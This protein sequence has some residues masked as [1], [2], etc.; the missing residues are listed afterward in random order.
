MSITSKPFVILLGLIT[1]AL[2]VLA[3]VLWRR[4]SGRG[5]APVLGRVALLVVGQLAF[6]ATLAAGIN[7]LF[8]FYTSWSELFGSGSQSYRLVD[9]GVVSG[10][11]NATQLS[12]PGLV[13]SAARTGEVVTETMVGLRS[14]IAARVRVYLPPRYFSPAAVHQYFPAV[15]VDDAGQTGGAQLAAQLLAAHGTTQPTAVVI[16]DTVDGAPL[17][18]MNTPD[19]AQGELFWSQDVRT[20]VASR[21]RIGLGAHSWAVLGSDADGACAASLAIADSAR[22]SAAAA[23][24]TWAPATASGPAPELGD[25]ANPAAWLRT[26]HAPPVQLLLSAQGGPVDRELDCV[27]RS[28]FQVRSATDPSRLAALDWLS[29]ALAPKGVRA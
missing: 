22:F 10:A 19:G 9:R 23:L 12:H 29:V 5:P 27:V 18:C 1:L 26:F 25:T 7:G 28:P 2:F 15:L 13:G 21:F 6:V 20:A 16:V 3:Q 11:V 8:G 24:G 17:P 14:D 4:L